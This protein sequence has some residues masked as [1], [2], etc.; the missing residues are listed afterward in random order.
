MS[1]G[2][3]AV[4]VTYHPDNDFARHISAVRAQVDGLV[5]VD[6]KSTD[7]ERLR[8]RELAR[9][10]SFTLLENPSNLGLGTALNRGIRWAVASRKFENVLL[11]D[12]DSEV[13]GDFVDALVLRLRQHHASDR[14]AI[15][16]PRICDRNTGSM[17]GPTATIKGRYLVAQTSGSL[18]P[19]AVFESEGWFRE[20]LF[21]DGVD[22]EYCLRVVTAGWSISYCP[23][24]VL[25]HAPGNSCRH[26]IWGL[27]LC[28]TMNYSALRH[29]Y[30]TRNCVWIM[31]RYW[32]LYPRWCAKLILGILK[33]K[34]KVVVFEENWRT[35]LMLSLCGF[36]DAL[37]GRLGKRQQAST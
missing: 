18:M 26:V 3:C 20:D 19:I 32:K 28:T 13:S 30:L 8:L 21:I 7:A 5:V 6:N 15:V 9:Y 35:K 37:H 4:V 31:R 11:L 2:V 33:D 14:V 1:I 24:A 27:D 23:E 29:Y 10:Y 34:A 25:S 22:Y 36:K 12:Q 16:A 17:V